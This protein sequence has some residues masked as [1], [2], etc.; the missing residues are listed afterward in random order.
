VNS[1]VIVPVTPSP[2]A[3]TFTLPVVVGA[4]R[5]AS[6]MPVVVLVVADRESRVPPVA[7]K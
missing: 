1:I 2:L 5:R 7:A 3:V 4:L 6:A